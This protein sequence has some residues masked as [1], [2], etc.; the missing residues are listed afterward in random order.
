MRKVEMNEMMAVDAGKISFYFGKKPV[1]T[2][3]NYCTSCFGFF[4][5]SD[6]SGPCFGFSKWD[7]DWYF[8]IYTIFQIFDFNLTD[9]YIEGEYEF[10]TILGLIKTIF[11]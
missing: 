9:G 6:A 1:N 4:D 7:G 3:Y 8:S 2:E 10:P 5:D 11:R